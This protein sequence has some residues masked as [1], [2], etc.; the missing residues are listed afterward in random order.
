[1]KKLAIITVV[2]K[3]YDVLEDYFASLSKQTDTK[4]TVFVIDTSDRPEYLTLPSYAHRVTMINRGY[5]A[6]VNKGIDE[7][8]RRGFDA[9]VITN[10]DIVFKHDFVSRVYQALERHPHSLIGGKIYYAKGYEYHKERYLEK[11]KGR[12]LWYAGGRISWEHA[13]TPHRGVDLVDR[14]Q[15]D[16]EG[17]TGFINGCLMIYDRQVYDKVGAWDESYFMYFEDSDYSVR[18]VKKGVDLWYDPSIVIWHKSAQSTGG[19]GS[20]FQMK[21]Q[22]KNQLR[23]GLKYAPLKTKLHL[24]KN[25]LLKGLF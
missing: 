2:Y 15:F 18:A 13:L 22:K 7:A 24:L 21:I 9:F 3:N 10:S 11:E 25:F 1:M 12:V 5:A 14:G 17:K 19:T 6:A 4:V 20:E 16:T 8:L 23:F